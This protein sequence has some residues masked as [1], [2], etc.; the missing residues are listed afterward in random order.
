MAESTA[1]PEEIARFAAIAAEWWDPEGKFRP[2]HAL[3]PARITFIRDRV[4]AL[5]GRDPKAPR[6]FDGLHLLD[7]GCGGGL[8]SEPMAR[9][10]ASVTGIDAGERMV[11]VA[12]L[13][14]R[15]SEL[16]IDYRVAT[17]EKLAQAGQRFDVV[18]NMEVVEHV[19]DLDLFLKACA[20]LLKPG[21]AMVV[22][23]LNRTAKSYAFAIVGAEYVLRWLP[24]GTHDWRKFV[25]PS[26]LAAGL[27]PHGVALKALKGVSYDPFQG[28]WRLTD[29]TA[30]NY[31]A[32]AV[33]DQG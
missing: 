24:R 22:A 27:R 21:G 25:K 30:V 3:N 20:N 33:K 9:L 2:L 11:E 12:R 14:A 29:D 13:H 15:Q 1:N 19:A 10:G 18:L 17:P 4:C 26:E 16:P 32:F 31:L 6:P 7:I 8:L 28:D 23:T 5:F